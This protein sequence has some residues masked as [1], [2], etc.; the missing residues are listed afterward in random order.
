[1]ANFDQTTYPLDGNRTE[2]AHDM[3]GAMDR[4]DDLRPKVRELSDGTFDG[5]RCVFTPMDEQ[6]S[7]NFRA[8][9]ATNRSTELDM[10]YTFGSPVTTIRGFVDPGSVAKRVTH[11][12][13]HVWSLMFYGEIV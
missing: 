9:L 11:G 12:R 1:M 4:T 8:Y 13:L 7:R 5:I 3:G 6:T 10:V 2:F